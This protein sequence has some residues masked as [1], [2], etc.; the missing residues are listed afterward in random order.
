M[1]LE[2]NIISYFAAF[3]GTVKDFSQI[4]SLFNAVFD[5]SFVQVDENTLNREQLKR[6]H[7]NGLALGSKARV[8][9]CKRT[10]TDSIEYKVFLTNRVIEDVVIHL[11]CKVKKGKIVRAKA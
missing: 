5:D 3:D 8:V 9:S 11:D 6:I 10:A 4:E 1:S 7:A 2:K